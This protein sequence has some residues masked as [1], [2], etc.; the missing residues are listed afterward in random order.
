ML[1]AIN[2]LLFYFGWKEIKDPKKNSRFENFSQIHNYNSFRIRQYQLNNASKNHS[3][4][5]FYQSSIIKLLLLQKNCR[6]NASVTIIYMQS[7]AWFGGLSCFAPFGSRLLCRTQHIFDD[8]ART[9]RTVKSCFPFDK[10]RYTR[11]WNT[12]IDCAPNTSEKKRIIIQ[13]H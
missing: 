9:R 11:M 6:L 12:T 13:F 4:V 10:M 5:Q 7:V 2:N 3:Q 8:G 1:M